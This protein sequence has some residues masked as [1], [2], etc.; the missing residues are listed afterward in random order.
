MYTVYQRALCVCTTQ[1]NNSCSLELS[2]ILKWKS[3]VSKSVG[4]LSHRIVSHLILLLITGHPPLACRVICHILSCQ[5]V[6]DSGCVCVAR[7]MSNSSSSPG[8][9]WGKL[10]SF[11]N[12]LLRQGTHTHPPE[13]HTKIPSGFPS[14]STGATICAHT[15]TTILLLI[16]GMNCKWFEFLSC[17][18]S[19]TCLHAQNRTPISESHPAQE[20]EATYF[21]HPTAN[22]RV[23]E[24]V[25]Q[26][27]I[28]GLGG[29][30]IFSQSSQDDGCSSQD[31]VS[32]S[33]HQMEVSFLE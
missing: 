22:C 9:Q 13:V 27:E 5:G 4:N 20:E 18:C 25:S 19:L 30:R 31:V 26:A 10:V 16:A 7:M 14:S 29:T 3:I 23:G 33:S 1:L 2:M 21:F 28:F 24:A 12:N 8:W 6:E 32:K 17:P 11:P 15:A